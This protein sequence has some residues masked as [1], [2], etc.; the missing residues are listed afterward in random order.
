MI[1]LFLLVIWFFLLYLAIF[2]NNLIIL[3]IFIF[4]ILIFSYFF[5]FFFSFSFSHYFCFLYP[6]LISILNNILFLLIST[7]YNMA[8]QL[9]GV[10]THEVPRYVLS[11]SVGS[12]RSYSSRIHVNVLIVLPV[13]SFVVDIQQWFS[14]LRQNFKFNLCLTPYILSVSHIQPFSNF[15]L[16]HYMF[17][18]PVS[19]NFELFLKL[20]IFF[21]LS[22]F[23][24]ILH[25]QFYYGVYNLWV[26]QFLFSD[27]FPTYRA[28]LH[29]L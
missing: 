25:S 18:F 1:R 12:K 11:T 7:F 6:F 3:C 19:S 14:I 17:L 8:V 28:N 16:F 21:H 10:R 23:S 4:F 24:L 9:I 29:L 27:I 26:L 20:A 15:N 13:P 2:L 5:S 22:T